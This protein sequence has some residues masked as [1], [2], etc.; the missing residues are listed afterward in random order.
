MLFENCKE[1]AL[2]TLEEAIE[3]I[4]FCVPEVKK[5]ADEAKTI[6]DALSMCD[7]PVDQ[8][9][10]IILYTMEAKAHEESVYY[11]LNQELRK[12]NLQEL[13]PW[14]LY[15]RLILTALAHIP[16]SSK[17]IYCGVTQDLRKEYQKGKTLFWWQFSSCTVSLH[18]LQNELFLG[19]KGPRTL[20]TIECNSGKDIR[21][22]FKYQVEDEILL[23]AA[24]QFK[25]ISCLEQDEGHCLVQLK[26]IQCAFE[27]DYFGPKPIF[28]P[29]PI[30]DILQ[31]I[32]YDAVCFVLKTRDEKNVTLAKTK[33][34]WATSQHNQRKLNRAFKDH[35][36]VLLFLSVTKSD[37]FQGIARLS[38]QSRHTDEEIAWIFHQGRKHVTNVFNIDWITC[39]MLRFCNIEHLLNSLD[40]NKPVTMSSDGQEIE[41]DC[42]KALC[43]LFRSDPNIDIMPI[44]TKAISHSAQDKQQSDPSS[45][46]NPV[47]AELDHFD[48]A[49][50]HENPQIFEKNTIFIRGLPL[51][52]T[53][54]CVLHTLFGEFS[55]VGQIKRNEKTNQLCINLRK[56]GKKKLRLTGN[57]TITFEAKESVRKAIEEYNGHAEDSTTKS[58]NVQR[59]PH[60]L[61]HDNNDDEWDLHEQ[62]LVDTDVITIV[63][64]LENSTSCVTLDLRRNNITEAGVA[65]LAKLLSKNQKL[66][67]LLLNFNKI[68]DHGLG[69]LCDVLTDKNSSLELLYINGNN[70]TN[71]GAEK[72]AEMLKKNKT[73]TDLSVGHNNISDMG[74]KDL[75]NTLCGENKTLKN[76]YLNSNRITDDSVD[77]IVQMLG[78]NKALERLELGDNQLLFDRDGKIRKAAE[79]RRLNGQNFLLV[80][81]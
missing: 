76:L 47:P 24:R 7:L 17:T 11:V 57:A 21:N 13:E 10:S 4:A 15:L 23:P 48:K 40:K 52:M 77:S 33:G 49:N 75:C 34:I 56:T 63:D 73:L 37:R 61:I 79:Q 6:S 1:K 71:T 44:V 28:P 14:L 30:A 39:E 62:S 64:V 60:T 68:D 16:S 27:L 66:E 65:H 50:V 29:K 25:V 8:V 70:I 31:H 5:M 41:L 12:K 35:R 51:D 58:T 53:E 19:R 22:Y 74:V 38:S 9:S 72:L 59:L 81:R 46:K 54:Q 43:C 36:N 55:T 67:E 3:P 42:A 78:V 69:R 45:A 20:F 18:V 2:V 80:V 26:E 32:L